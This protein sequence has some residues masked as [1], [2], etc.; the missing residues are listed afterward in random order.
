M[1]AAPLT[2]G[3]IR[4]RIAEPLDVF[5]A[6]WSAQRLATTIGFAPPACGEI[7]IVVSELATNILKYGVRGAIAM[8]RTDDAAFGPGLEL[9]ADD[10][11]PLLTDL[12]TA[13]QDGCGDR[14]PI[15]P[16][17]QLGRGGIGA[18]LGA[19]IRLTDRFEYLPHG[20]RKSFR[21]IRYLRRPRPSPLAATLGKAP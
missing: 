3:V 1:T 10:E 15:D 21:A 18:G 6:R 16:C 5:S 17:R 12:A 7:A 13:V 8:Q 14:G 4:A 20:A 2:T 11:G 19:I 9:V